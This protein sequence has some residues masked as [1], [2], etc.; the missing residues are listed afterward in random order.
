MIVNEMNRPLELAGSGSTLGHQ[1]LTMALAILEERIRDL[2]AEDKQDLFALIKELPGSDAEEL[3]SILIS[4]REILE[5]APARMQPMTPPG[6][7]SGVAPGLKRW[8]DFV[9]RRIVEA[10]T[11]AGLTQSELAEKT[12]LPQSHISRLEC[13]K[14][15]PSHVT[16]ERIA[17]ALGIPLSQLDPSAE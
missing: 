17:T 5:Q 3:A 4:M 1:A 7:R 9:S 8:M 10:R 11:A 12:G 13:A 14:H 16:L 15:S 6:S 2:S